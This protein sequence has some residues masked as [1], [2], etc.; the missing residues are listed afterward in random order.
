MSPKQWWVQWTTVPGT[1]DMHPADIFWAGVPLTNNKQWWTPSPSSKV[2][3]KIG[4]HIPSS[5]SSS[6]FPLK[7]AICGGPIL[8]HT[9]FLDFKR[10]VWWNPLRYGIVCILWAL[11]YPMKF[12]VQW[13]PWCF[14]ARHAH[15]AVLLVEAMLVSEHRTCRK[16]D[17]GISRDRTRWSKDDWMMW[18]NR[19][20]IIW[21]NR[22]T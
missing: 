10:I 12:R 2:C 21:G 1:S 13:I 6:F 14:L 8:S 22:T 4:Y 7:V 3:L 17:G 18:G 19:I 11:N 16:N 5:G 15:G 20:T 9:S